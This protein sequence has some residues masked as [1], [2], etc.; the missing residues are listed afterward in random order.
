MSRIRVAY[1]EGS[2]SASTAFGGS[3]LSLLTLL[4]H[5]DRDFV[6]PVVILQQHGAYEDRLEAIDVPVFFPAG[7]A[8][9]AEGSAAEGPSESVRPVAQR[10]PLVSRVRNLL[11][12]LRYALQVERA[13]AVRLRPLLRELAPDLVHLNNGVTPNRSALLASSGCWAD[14]QDPYSFPSRA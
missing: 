8:P 10:S 3:H 7:A 12:P 5:L 2:V 9:A 1:I 11:S 14:R 6:E 4:T 13:R